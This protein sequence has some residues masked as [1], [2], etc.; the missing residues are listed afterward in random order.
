M[1]VIPVLRQHDVPP[2][3]PGST[4]G[5]GW[6]RSQPT[7]EPLNRGQSLGQGRLLRAL[8]PVAVA[9]LALVA[10]SPLFSGQMV[11][12]HDTL[13]HAM[14]TA[15]FTRA[16]GAGV[17]WPEWAPNLGGGYG[18]PIFLFNPPLFYF[19]AAIPTLVGTP[20]PWA[21]NLTCA[22]LIV[23]ASLGVYAWTARAFGRAGAFVAAVAYVWAP[24]TLLDLYVRQALTELTA[25]CILPWALWGLA[26][27]CQVPGPR[28]LATAALAIGAL[29]LASTPAALVA[30]PA[31]VGQIAILVHHRRPEGAA[32]GLAA[33]ALGATLAAL[34]WVPAST[35][36]WL[37]RFDRLLVGEPAYQ[38]HFVE[39]AQ[40]VSSAWGY[41]VSMPGPKDGMGF[42]LG[43]VQLALVLG[44]LAL[45]APR[46]VH[47]LI[48]RQV[49][50]AVGLAVLGV[51]MSTNTSAAVWER[52]SPLHYLQFPWRFLLLTALGC[53]VLAAAPTAIVARRYPGLAVMT[54]AACAGALVIGGWARAQPGSVVS[55][56][57]SE[58]SPAAIAGRDRARGTA[59]E[60]E[61]V[62]M[63]GRPARSPAA[64]LTLK[65]G[66]ALVAEQVVT[67]HQQ[68][69]LVTTWTRSTLRLNTFYFPGW[70]LFVDGHE[71]PIDYANPSGL[72]EFSL[73]RGEHLVEARFTPTSDRRL[74]GALSVA[75]LMTLAV[76]LVWPSRRRRTTWRRHAVDRRPTVAKRAREAD[77]RAPSPEPAHG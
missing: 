53:A 69:F 21:M 55:V 25:I 30:A 75:G 54:A 19:I 26:Q 74:G 62:W 37:L 34:F 56:A 77:H 4:P 12:G 20:I 16:L 57:T 18:E 36:R 11:N 2:E 27:T 46:R 63:E 71:R 76:L 22:F 61:T 52:L 60:Y 58:F 17:W 6:P 47:G 7:R 64:R 33:L 14:R 39:P 72:I 73:D 48:G 35:E 9:A 5:H 68:R 28:R 49:W 59:H 44:G 40:L 23:L 67:A 41:G 24:Y 13:E 3:E 1:Q 45:L 65:S 51:I 43:E 70:R 29:L 31:L 50:L 38:N 10:A 32:R 15:E 42:G 66:S 8:P